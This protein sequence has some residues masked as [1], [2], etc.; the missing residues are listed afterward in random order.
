MYLSNP[1]S[2]MFMEGEVDGTI[3]LAKVHEFYPLDEG[4][5]LRG[6]IT[7]KLMFEGNMSAI[8]NERY[9][10]FRLMGSLLM[11]DFRY[12][13]PM[14]N[15]PVDIAK[16]QLNF[17]PQSVDLINFKMK[18]GDN[19]FSATGKVEGFLPYALND[20]TLKGNLQTS[21]TYFNV[22][23]LLPENGETS[24]AETDTAA[25]SVIEI[26]E[27]IDFTMQSTFKTLIYDDIEF[28]NVEGKLMVKDQ[29]VML[30]NLN[31][32]VLDGAIVMS[33]KYDTED[34]ANPVADFDMDI[35]G[36]DIQQSYNTFGTIEKFA[37]IAAKTSGKFS[38]GF[39]VNTLL[40][41][42]MMPVYA[43]MNGGGNLSTT[44]ITI[45]NVNT[46][47]KLADLLKMPDLKRLRLD[48]INLTFE[49]IEGK[50]HIKPFDI[51]YQDINAN[52]LGW[53]SFDQMIDFDMVLTIPRA[54][55]GGAANDVLDNLV[56]EANRLGTNFSLG[57]NVNVHAK[58]TGPANDPSVRITPGEAAGGS[59]LEDL[60]KKAQDELDRQKQ[61]L[62][63]EA[64]KELEKKKAEARDKAEKLIADADRQ[65]DKIIA[66][67]QKQADAIN[68]AARESADKLIDE[69]DKQAT[70]LEEEA[71]E[72]GPIAEM[73]GKKAAERVR[74]EASN[75]AEQLVNEAESRSESIIREARNQ[76]ANLKANAQK[77]ADELL[78]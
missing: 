11:D 30:D 8:E 6:E 48:P 22:T 66:E 19:D 51:K 7:A 16:A 46:F 15:K 21:S 76:A 27:K 45:E 26:P 33:G 43:S 10:E 3:N 32:E 34:P 14:L 60:K 18:M 63:E 23:S 72:R 56:S 38:A 28:E 57:D 52:I 39:Q 58:I 40:D 65:A 67:A 4:D 20:G 47:N 78:E 37:P 31:M 53:S 75:K 35:I 2:D 70:K 64:R 41:K 5:R 17:S 55:F 62:E 74:T 12:T 29:A 54:K 50:V 71:K 59:M 25:L 1:V 13:S 36:I 42:E 44:D 73:A 61:N 9:D 49:F 77:E 24:A 69:A 68:R